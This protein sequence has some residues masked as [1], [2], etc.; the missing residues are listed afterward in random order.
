M[1]V[2]IFNR[3]RSAEILAAE[4]LSEIKDSKE[5]AKIDRLKVEEMHVI[6]QQAMGIKWLLLTIG[7]LIGF[8]AAA[9]ELIDIFKK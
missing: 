4:I 8:A 5:L 6:Y 1:R 2:E 3:L 7:T 9:S